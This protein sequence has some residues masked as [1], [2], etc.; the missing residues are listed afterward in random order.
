MVGD[1]EVD[2]L[3]AVVAKDDEDEQQTEG[4]GGDHEE[5]NRDEFS[6][7]HGEKD[8]PRG[9]GPRCSSVHVL[10][11]GEFSDLVTEQGEFHRDAPPAP[12][13][14]LPRH[15]SDEAADLGVE[16][17]AAH[18]VPARAKNASEQPARG[19]ALA[20]LSRLE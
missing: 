1:V 3:A 4:E 18:S 12:G 11:D 13:G 17:R 9:R 20:A 5:V 6:E 16:P 7:V 14:I 8:A 19:K 15:A 2:E 10:G